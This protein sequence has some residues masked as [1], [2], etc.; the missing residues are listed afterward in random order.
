MFFFILLKNIL[1]LLLI[2]FVFCLFSLVKLFNVCCF[3][4]VMIK[5]VIIIRGSVMVDVKDN[6]NFLEMFMESF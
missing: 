3:N 6:F 1:M 5:M 4:W 2:C